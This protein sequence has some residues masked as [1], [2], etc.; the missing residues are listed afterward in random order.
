MRRRSSL[1]GL[2][3]QLLLW[4]G[5]VAVALS[6]LAMHQLSGNHTA[7]G[8]P[9]PVSQVSGAGGHAPAHIDD[10]GQLHGGDHPHAA[11]S[12]TAAADG[13][14]APGYAC[15]DCGGH[16]AMMLTCL[17]ALALLAVGLSLTRPARWPGR[18]PRRWRW[19]QPA[20]WRLRRHP[21]PLSLVEL[22]ISRT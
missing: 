16:Q 18:L 19:T 17:A 1:R 21:P 3:R 11:T 22:S 2:Q 6:L 7:A 10:A 15:P 5:V 13:L 4:A 12:L 8:A 9:P 20:A 14:P